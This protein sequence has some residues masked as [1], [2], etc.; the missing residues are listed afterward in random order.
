MKKGEITLIAFA[1]F[2]KAFDTV[3]YCTIIKRLHGIGFSQGALNWIL[4]YFSGRN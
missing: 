2:S 1:D 4:N 3:D